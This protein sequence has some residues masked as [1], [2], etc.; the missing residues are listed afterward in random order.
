MRKVLTVIGARPQFIKAGPVS[1]AL[2][3]KVSEIVVN[4]G[5]HYDY[6]M[7]EVFFRDLGLREPDHSLGVGSGSHAVQTAAML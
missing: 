2:A 1:A 7:S 4:T 5:Q 6:Q 3:G